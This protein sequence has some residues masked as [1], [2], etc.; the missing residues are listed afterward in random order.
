MVS[1]KKFKVSED[2]YAESSGY[3]AIL[4]CPE[5]KNAQGLLSI[6][7][8]DIDGQKGALNVNDFYVIRKLRGGNFG[9][10]YACCNKTNNKKYALKIMN[11]GKLKK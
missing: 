8:N 7:T 3:F 1:G 9:R 10:V 6:S 2:Y 5:K 11:K 4:K